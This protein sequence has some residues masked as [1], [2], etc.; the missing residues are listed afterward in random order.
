M[1]T[2]KTQPNG[3][4]AQSENEDGTWTILDLNAIPETDTILPYIAPTPTPQELIANL[5][6]MV[7]PR[8]QREAT[9]GTDNG[10]LKALEA[11]IEAIR[12]TI[13]K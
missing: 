12:V 7:T 11:Q 6:A 5:E 4:F 1:Q 8:R 9:L 3:I 13:P 10:W 2:W